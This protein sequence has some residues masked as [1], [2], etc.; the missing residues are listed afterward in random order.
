MG[1][2]PFIA[3][4][5]RCG[6]SFPSAIRAAPQPKPGLS[7]R[8]RPQAL[9]FVREAPRQPEEVRRIRYQRKPVAG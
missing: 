8:R 3:S 5:R 6:A 2:G 1:R 9:T 7:P 4:L